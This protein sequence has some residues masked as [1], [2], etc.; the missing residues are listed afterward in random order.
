MGY[1]KGIKWDEDLIENKIH[2]VMRILGIDRM[3]SASETE[4]ILRD[5]SLSNKIA[6][7]G[8]F[9]TWAKRLMLEIKSSE[10]QLGQEFEVKARKMIEDRGYSTKQMSCKYPFDILVNDKISIDVKSAKVYLSHGSRVHTVGINKKYATC[11]LYLIF[12]L[13]ESENIE[14]TFIVP[15]C[16]IRVT[17]MNFG[18]NSKY[19]MYLNKWDLLKKY[20]DFYNNLD[21]IGGV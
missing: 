2:E 17:S 6:K 18:E 16:D 4:L 11:D 1:V 14:R 15:G 7:T 3:P 19:N 8:G 12:A 10:T 21:S 9:N 5:S 13:D 20:D